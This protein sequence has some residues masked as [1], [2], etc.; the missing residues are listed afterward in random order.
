MVPVVAA[1]L[2]QVAA[3]ARAVAVERYAEA[4]V[5]SAASCKEAFEDDDASAVA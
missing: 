1:V 5:C 3:V 2:A 4:E